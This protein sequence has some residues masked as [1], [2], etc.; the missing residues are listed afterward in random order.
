MSRDDRLKGSISP[1]S[2]E[3]TYQEPHPT[4]PVSQG[5]GPSRRASRRCR[6]RSQEGVFC[7]GPLRPCGSPSAWLKVRDYE[8]GLMVLVAWKYGED[9]VNYVFK[10]L[11]FQEARKEGS[12]VCSSFFV[13]M[14]FLR[15]P[16]QAL[17]R[18]LIRKWSGR[19]KNANLLTH[20]QKAV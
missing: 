11:C 7:V 18:L 12:P 20:R 6:S 10:C 15:P 17:R 8:M 4:D 1:H 14:G 13:E 16:M 19:V 9:R 3:T 5:L 2:R